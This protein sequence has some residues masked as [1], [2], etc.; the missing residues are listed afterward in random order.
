MES[1]VNERIKMLRSSQ[2]LSQQEFAARINTSLVTISRIENGVNEPRQNTLLTICREFGVS[3]QWL[4]EGI[5]E[6]FS[7]GR[8]KAESKVNNWRDEAYLKLE[9]YNESLKSEVTF[10]K[11]IVNGLL[12]AQKSFNIGAGVSGFFNE[13]LSSPVRVRA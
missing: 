12:P 10:L 7:E 5:G 3:E 11:S 6:M 8:I 9:E 2:N 13:E 1:R 4:F